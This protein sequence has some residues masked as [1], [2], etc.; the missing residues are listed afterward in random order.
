MSA[1]KLTVWSDHLGRTL[2]RAE[3]TRI[4]RAYDAAEHGR[5]RAGQSRAHRA[6]ERL[7]REGLEV[8][9]AVVRSVARAAGILRPRGSP[10]AGTRE[11]TRRMRTIEEEIAGGKTW[12]EIGALLGISGGAARMWW[13]RA[14]R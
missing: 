2:T 4:L 7:A 10:G 12:A 3:C 9:A 11:A 1:S 8:S 5:R 6:Q 13:T 14:T